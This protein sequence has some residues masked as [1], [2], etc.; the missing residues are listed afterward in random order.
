[1]VWEWQVWRSFDDIREAFEEKGWKSGFVGCND[2]GMMP[3]LAES[4]DHCIAFFERNPLTGEC[5]FELR[6]KAQHRVVFVRGMQNIPR[7]EQAVGLLASYGIPL[8]EMKD[9]N[10]LPLYDLP[11]TPV[12]EA[13]QSEG[14]GQSLGPLL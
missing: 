8:D 2:N 11:V 7:A 10:D 13:G 4:D 12:L 3:L 1:V 5:S 6:D 9:P 14:R